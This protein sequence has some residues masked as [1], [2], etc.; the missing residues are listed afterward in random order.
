MARSAGVLLFKR[1]NNT[2]QVF[3][4]HPGGPFFAKR[5]QGSWSIPK[6]GIESGESD[7]EAGMRELWEETSIDLT[8]TAEANFLDLGNIKY[9]SGKLIH[10]F[11][12]EFSEDFDFK[13]INTTIEFPYKS[14]KMLQIPENDRGEWFSI[15]DALLKLNAAQAGILPRLQEALS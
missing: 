13:S 5:D 8:G 15:Q 1:I 4:V 3:L 14:G 2:L 10:F 9:A 7:L 11:A 6:G 12:F